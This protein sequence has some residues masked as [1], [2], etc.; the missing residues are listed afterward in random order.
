MASLHKRSW[1]SVASIWVG[2]MFIIAGCS[3]GTDD[4]ARITRVAYEWEKAVLD[5]DRGTLE[6][7]LYEDSFG[8][9]TT[10]K[11]IDSGLKYEDVT[12]EVY[13]DKQSGQYMV[14]SEYRVPATKETVHNTIVLRK[15]GGAWKVDLAKSDPYSLDVDATAFEKIR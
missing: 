15:H 13:V 1:I 12:F 2:L 3:S 9:A 6:S 11:N 7:L 8:I 10:D 4:T 5:N 14:A